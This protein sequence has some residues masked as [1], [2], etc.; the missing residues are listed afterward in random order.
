MDANTDNNNSDG[1]ANPTDTGTKKV[2]RFSQTE[3]VKLHKAYLKNILQYP[4]ILGVLSEQ[5]GLSTLSLREYEVGFIPVTPYDTGPA[6]SF[7]ERNERGDIIGITVRMMDGKKLEI[8]GSK[9]GLTYRPRYETSD[10]EKKKWQRVSKEYPCP[11]CGKSDGCL[12]PEN[13]YEHPA[14][15][16]CVHIST[17]SE[18]PLGVGHLHILDP[19]RNARR[20]KGGILGHSDRPIIITEGATDAI[21]AADMGFISIGR[22][23]YAVGDEDALISLVQGRSVVIIGDR[24]KESKIGE[25]G[26]EAVF[27]LLRDEC[28]SVVKVLPPEGLKDLRAWKNAGLTQ[29][30]LLEYIKAEGNAR[31]KDNIFNDKKP[32]TIAK[33][34]LRD[35]KTQNGKLI[36]RKY[37]GEHYE[38]NGQCYKKTSL[39][40]LYGELNVYFENKLYLNNDKVIKPCI[41]TR[42]QIRDV[43]DACGGFYLIDEDIS[44]P[45][46]LN[47][48]EKT[49]KPERLVAFRNGILNVDEYLNGKIILHNPDP[50]YFSFNVLPYDFDENAES[51]TWN[52]FLKDIFEGDEESIILLAQ[53]FGHVLVPDMSLHKQMFFFGPPRTGKST[54][55]EALASMLGENNYAAAS[56]RDLNESFGFEDLP[57][58]LAVVMGDD[59]SLSRKETDR[60]LAFIKN[61]T[62]GGLTKIN[63]KFQHKYTARLCCRFTLAMN[64]LPPFTDNTK[65]LIPRTLVLS[66][67]N[68]YIGREDFSLPGKLRKEAESGKL[69][70][71]ALRGLMSL[72]Q[73]GNR[74]TEPKHSKEILRDFSEQV[75]PITE[76]IEDC[77]DTSDP[78][79][80]L[81]TNFLYDVWQWWCK[82]ENRFPGF[83]NTFVRNFLTNLPDVT[84]CRPRKEGERFRAL[85][86]VKLSE[87]TKNDFTTGAR[88]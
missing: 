17:G 45:C 28:N 61:V 2:K 79:S 29:E 63:K 82:S 75:S 74:F 46:W 25:K 32:V 51:E 60:V 6:W 38:F 27:A 77:I 7:P 35:Q 24:D 57:G 30:R 58:K 67:D 86:G 48:N 9:R 26:M 41:P 5:L 49:P 87:K 54:T 84:Q 88:T 34:W 19:A 73:N 3:L 85:T 44:P 16:C 70:N 59:D 36:L 71:F 81:P 21:A 53:W 15:V 47:K 22:A 56:Y 14:A 78:Q 8:A 39:D 31:L 68:S 50:D 12:Y 66:F 52:D 33:D 40:R 13:E 20:V 23:N 76:F 18:R 43:L 10:Y 42:A 11:L 4:A 37:Q 55:L 65:S 72:H 1:A 83:K 62:G 69:I 80:T 64:E